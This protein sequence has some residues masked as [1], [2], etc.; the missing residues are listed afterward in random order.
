[1]SRLSPTVRTH[2]GVNS[3]EDVGIIEVPRGILIRHY[4]E[5]TKNWVA[6]RPPVVSALI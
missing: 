1:V 5:S 6:S 3:P 2:T 4:K